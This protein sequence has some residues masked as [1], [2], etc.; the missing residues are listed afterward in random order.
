MAVCKYAIEMEQGSN[1]FKVT[2][3]LKSDENRELTVAI[4]LTTYGKPA[5]YHDKRNGVLSVWEQMDTVHG[6][7][8]TAVLVNPEIY[9]GYALVN[10][11]EMILIKV[12][13]NVPFTYYAGAAWNKN[14]NFKKSSYWKK[15]VKLTTK[16][17]KF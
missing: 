7:L 11:D 1:F 9:T 10:G 8:G 3:T 4:G 6:S 2:S 14:K 5:V 15:Y 16:K 13:T 12:H 17:V